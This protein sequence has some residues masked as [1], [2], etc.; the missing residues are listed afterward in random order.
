MPTAAVRLLWSVPDLLREWLAF[1]GGGARRP[2]R[3]R[4]CAAGARSGTARVATAR[5]RRAA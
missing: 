4:G 3:R 5:W 1:A 2:A